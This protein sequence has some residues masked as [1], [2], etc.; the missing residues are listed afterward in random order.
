MKSPDVS[1]VMA[2]AHPPSKVPIA[3]N[4]DDWWESRQPA[5]FTDDAERNP[6]LGVM[7]GDLYRTVEDGQILQRCPHIFS[8]C[9][10]PGVHHALKD[11]VINGYLATC[12]AVANLKRIANRYPTSPPVDRSLVYV[13]DHFLRLQ[14][15]SHG[16]GYMLMDDSHPLES[17]AVNTPANGT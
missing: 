15:R 14:L 8:R 9:P 11:L 2:Y 7:L 1:V 5:S 3:C 13:G 12:A 16:E 17:T 10:R 6:G 4:P